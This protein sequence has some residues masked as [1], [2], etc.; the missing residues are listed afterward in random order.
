MLFLHACPE[1]QKPMTPGSLLP[2]RGPC[3][4]CVQKKFNKIIFSPS[5][6]PPSHH[7]VAPP[8]LAKGG[9]ANERRSGTTRKETTA[10]V[11]TPNPPPTHRQTV[12]AT[13][14]SQRG[15]KRVRFH[16]PPAAR[17]HRKEGGGI[18]TESSEAIDHHTKGDPRDRSSF[19]ATPQVLGARGSAK[20]RGGGAS[21]KYQDQGKSTAEQEQ[22]VRCTKCAESMT[23]KALWKHKRY[24]C[25]GQ[26]Q[27]SRTKGSSPP[28]P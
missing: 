13:H 19:V 7:S 4:R 15:S 10:P 23:R 3:D 25:R 20:G 11:D 2:H 14:H 26:D 6:D 1:C 18:Q 16:C 8:P 9:S 17:P 24:H 12:P 21:S 28:S 5:I 22:M 27:G